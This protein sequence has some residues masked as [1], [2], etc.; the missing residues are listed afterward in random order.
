MS[1]KRSGKKVVSRNVAIALV[2]ISIVLLVGLVG[3][4]LN[5]TSIIGGKD[6]QTQTLTN[7]KNQLQ[8]WLQGNKTLLN[9]TQ[10]WLQG[11]NSIANLTT[12]T[13]WVA[14]KNV[15]IQASS[16]SV[17][18]FTANYAGYISV[19]VTGNPSTTGNFYV[20]VTYS[21]HGVNYDNQIYA[22]ISGT[23]VFPVLPASIKISIGN[24]GT[25]VANATVTMMYYY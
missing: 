21:S 10:T 8:T 17:W 22:G 1:A 3:A 20:R 7:Q 16:E 24:L 2:I 19:Q 15:S 9:Q 4:M 5:Y 14:S 23:A 25:A 11:N 18:N 13:I 12:S 6:S